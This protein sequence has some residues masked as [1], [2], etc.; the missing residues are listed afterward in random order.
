MPTEPLSS[1]RP[2]CSI[3][4]SIRRVRSLKRC[5]DGPYGILDC[6]FD[7]RFFA[8]GRMAAKKSSTE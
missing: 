3:N 2:P 7:A 8:N 5:S 4:D 1:E 6:L